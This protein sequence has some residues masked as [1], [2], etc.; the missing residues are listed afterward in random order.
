MIKSLLV[1]TYV[2]CVKF[3]NEQ[4]VLA[5]AGNLCQ[6][7]DVN[8]SKLITSSTIFRSQRIHGIVVNKGKV[9]F[10][11]G[12]NLALVE[13]IRKE[14]HL[15]FKIIC[16]W[17]TGHWIQDASFFDND[18]YAV[19]GSTNVLYLYK[20][21]TNKG[22]LLDKT[23]H[24]QEK[25][26]LYSGK[27][28]GT[29]WSNAVVLCGTVFSQVT[30]WSPTVENGHIFHRLIGHTGVIFS[31]T[32]HEGNQTIC[33]TSDDR[34]LR[35]WQVQMET[36]DNT[37]HSWQHAK[38]TLVYSIFGHTAR[39]WRN[40]Q[41][42]N[43][44]IISIGEDGQLKVW[45]KDTCVHYW[46]THQNCNVWSMDYDETSQL[47]VTGGGDG[48]VCVWPLSG[49]K[50]AEPNQL[51]INLSAD[52]FPRQV[53]MT[54]G[55][56]LLIYTNSGT[57]LSYV[58]NNSK[59]VLEDSRFR[60]YCILSLSKTR[61]H[62]STASIS[63]DILIFAE[64]TDTLVCEYKACDSKIYSF[65]WLDRNKFVICKPQGKL[66]VLQFDHENSK[67]RE[68]Y[69]LLLP[70]C[71]ERWLTSAI[72]VENVFICGDRDG[73]IHVYDGRNERQIQTYHKIH[74]RLG[75]SCI[76]YNA[77]Q[78]KLLSIGRD[79]FLR[80]WEIK[81]DIRNSIKG[82]VSHG[83]PN[84][85]DISNSTKAN[86]HDDPTTMKVNTTSL[87][88]VNE[89]RLPLEWPAHIVSL[90]VHTYIIGFHEVH[91]IIW[92]TLEQKVIL[93]VQC[94]GGHR[95]W[96]YFL[97]GSQFCFS[98][99][100][101]KRVFYLNVDLSQVTRPAIVQSF[102]RDEINSLR[103]VQ[104]G[105]EQIILSGGED[106][107]L[108]I[109][110]V[111]QTKEQPMHL[112]TKLILRSHI[113]SIRCVNCVTLRNDVYIVSGGGRA[114]LKIWKLSSN[115][116]EEI[117]M[118]LIPSS[119]L[120]AESL[121]SDTKGHLTFNETIG[122][123]D[124]Q[125]S[126]FNESIGSQDSQNST[127]N[128]TN[129]T[130]ENSVVERNPSKVEYQ[131]KEILSHMLNG[132]DRREKSWKLIQPR[133]NPET[134]Y[135]DVALLCQGQDRIYVATACSDGFVRL[136][137]YQIEEKKFSPIG[138]YGHHGKCVLRVHFVKFEN[139]TLLCSM[140]TNGDLA[141]WNFE[142]LVD[143]NLAESSSESNDCKNVS[144]KFTDK[145][146]G[147][148]KTVE[149]ST[150]ENSNETKTTPNIDEDNERQR[151][152]KQKIVC[153]ENTPKQKAS[154][155]KE[156]PI[157]EV[158]IHPLIVYN[159]LHQGGINSFDSRV[160]G[161]ECY[162]LT[163]GDDCS[164]VLTIIKADFTTRERIEKRRAHNSQITG[165]QFLDDTKFV[166]SSVDQQ[167]IVWTWQSQQ[168]VRL[169]QHESCIP[170][171]HGVDVIDDLVV[172]YGCGV[173]IVKVGNWMEE[174]R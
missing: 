12:F 33:S 24:C 19:L 154:S 59:L 86:S 48:G 105:G 28:L 36:S 56:K 87:Y 164:L 44:Q 124:N 106:N 156:N 160:I 158:N 27:I 38:I 1:K 10:L 100:K 109:S 11:G 26:V 144:K 55:D 118:P 169:D 119:C 161:A 127:F 167:I 4:Y 159:D 70:E 9:L 32:Y 103:F 63:G 148:I 31:V 88:P 166:S 139:R 5:S 90:G 39:V 40:F 111:S 172:V 42:N 17:T 51:D 113:S 81:E 130:G 45:W 93:K 53:V 95:S 136:F 57:V 76:E 47:I 23:K 163:G 141:L 37:V 150:K 34:S 137:L 157:C 116:K 97:S 128:G 69:N 125:N 8:T 168:L 121:T 84:K 80:H 25:S 98:F 2:N 71:K 13:I 35:V 152:A 126:T 107:T 146:T 64:D 145:V 162:L 74:S 85:E 7:Y 16:E 94:G 82:G 66:T 89:D 46:N 135:M 123:Q 117:K 171:I 58:R 114:Q 18:H 21:D 131:C 77:S 20:Y 174:K 165:V 79:G 142:Q 78:R 41:L 68:L 15:T 101:Q 147:N 155:Q 75:V 108:R 102:H 129:A 140:S 115:I 122:S 173:N 6:V 133:I 29:T 61:R 22:I 143:N 132:E 112:Q 73:S 65:H 49:N 96:D 138:E 30:V 91:L 67:V 153:E 54:T 83:D 72:L 3:L 99:I 134:R 170:D 110:S 43:G 104:I 14:N 50:R 60:S 149:S 62:Y 151:Q 92:S 52:D 120:E